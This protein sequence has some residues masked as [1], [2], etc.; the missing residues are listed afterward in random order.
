MHKLVKYE[1]QLFLIYAPVKM[2]TILIL[3]FVENSRLRMLFVM[4]V[5]DAHEWMKRREREIYVCFRRIL[6]G[7][8]F[9]SEN[10][11]DNKRM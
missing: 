3:L 1:K 11:N 4:F 5:N 2:H 7:I 6:K 10:R 9:T 8:A